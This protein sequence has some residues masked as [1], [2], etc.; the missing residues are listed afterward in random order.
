MGGK[1][2]LVIVDGG[3]ENKLDDKMEI[4]LKE[5]KWVGVDLEFEILKK[6]HKT[7]Q[8]L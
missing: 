6:F 8:V 1:E 5:W 2:W 4:L 3:R 7:S